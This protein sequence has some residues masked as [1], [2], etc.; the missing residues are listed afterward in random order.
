VSFPNTNWLVLAQATL[1]G[2]DE[3]RRALAEI[4]EQYWKPVYYAICALGTDR[5]QAK[6]HT[7]AFF[8]YVMENSTLRRADRVRGKFRSFLQAVLWRF[9]RDQRDKQ[10]AEKRGGKAATF[11]LD[12][13][14]DE[15]L[16]SEA[17][18]LAETLDLEW[19]MT[20][21]QKVIDTLRS[22]VVQSRGEHAWTILSQFLPGGSGKRT[23]IEAAPS[24]GLSENGLRSEIHRLRQ[25]CREALRYELLATVSSPELVNE[26]IAYFGRILKLHWQEIAPEA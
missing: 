7:Q 22:E 6:D 16:P 25:R 12:E 10:F 3:G 2:N 1:H 9:L 24:L 4:C 14:A 15:E 13:L 21:F 17:A 19:A 11:A 18:P 8:S 26:E 23:A 5:E 20:V